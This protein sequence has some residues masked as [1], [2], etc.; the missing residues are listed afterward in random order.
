MQ[1]AQASRSYCKAELGHQE[2]PRLLMREGKRF[3]LFSRAYYGSPGVAQADAG[4]QLRADGPELAQAGLQL[5][6]DLQGPGT[7]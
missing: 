3:Q 4:A 2:H 1:G 5:V 7:S 6:V